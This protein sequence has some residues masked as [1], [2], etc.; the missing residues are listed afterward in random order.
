MFIF[1]THFQL[2]LFVPIRLEVD[3]RF[4]VS[5]GFLGVN[6]FSPGDPAK[7]QGPTQDNCGPFEG[8]QGEVNFLSISNRCE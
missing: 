7:L 2:M 8:C 1:S 6:R 5:R 3:M 4:A